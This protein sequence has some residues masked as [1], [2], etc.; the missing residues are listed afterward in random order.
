MKERKAGYYSE[1][2]DKL[3]AQGHYVEAIAAYD[4]ALAADP[5]LGFV[6]SNRGTAL[7]ALGRLEEALA[8]HDRAV[9]LLPRSAEAHFCRAN[10][11]RVLGRAHDALAAFDAAL[12]QNQLYGPAWANRGNTL[13][14]LG[15]AAEAVEA[16]QRALATM[17]RNARYYVNLGNAKRETGALKE[18]IADYE[19]AIYLQPTLAE[20]HWNKGEYAAGWRE[21][22]WRKRMP[23]PVGDRTYPF[24]PWRGE[25]LSGRRLL[26][27]WEQGLGDTIQFCRYLPLL[28]AQGAQLLFAPQKGLAHLMRGLGAE[29]VDAE[30][31]DLVADFHVPLLSVPLLLGTNADTIPAGLPYLV[32]DSAR[33]AA[34]RG[35]LPAEG[36][37]IGVCWQGGIGPQDVGRSIPLKM[38]ASL[39]S[40]PGV[41]L[42]SLHRG[43]GEAQLADLPKVIAFPALDAGADAFADT[44]AL[45]KG[46]DLVI[47]SDTAVAHLAGALGAQT[48]VAL[49]QVPDWRWLLGR[50]DSPWYPGMRLFRQSSSGDWDGVTASIMAAL[51]LLQ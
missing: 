16:H 2:G 29:I 50:H 44:S 28:K 49:K 43:I 46:L 5:R 21:Y 7:Q 47:T 45:I 17:P 23:H 32:A 31:P 48:W 3:I 15:R 11:L 6:F 18:A 26:V 35:C 1:H 12:S 27:H 19:Q 34:W 9:A 24:P 42:F 4:A 37:R 39:A 25:D 36:L 22:E 33:V 51:K 20:A 10:A 8:S 40:L 38:F 13:L 41:Q 14:D 30:S